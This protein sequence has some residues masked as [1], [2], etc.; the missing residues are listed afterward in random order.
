[1]KAAEIEPKDVFQSIDSLMD[2]VVRVRRFKLAERMNLGGYSYEDANDEIMTEG[3]FRFDSGETHG[4][5]I[6]RSMVRCSRSKMRC[7]HVT[8]DISHLKEDNFLNFREEEY[9]IETWDDDQ[10]VTGPFDYECVRYKLRVERRLR[11][12]RLYRTPI[13]ESEI[14]K[15]F[16][17]TEKVLSLLDSD[18]SLK[19]WLNQEREKVER[20]SP[21]LKRLR[22]YPLE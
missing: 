7:R 11:T 21:R 19:Q 15:A 20:L 8:V 17:K 4:I 22:E 13:S 14:C 16:D 5:P 1:M 10:V 3:T 6:Q 18:A 12:V 9:G 2:G